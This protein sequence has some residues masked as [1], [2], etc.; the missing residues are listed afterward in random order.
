MRATW[1]RRMMNGPIP[2]V[3]ARYELGRHAGRPPARQ[4][5]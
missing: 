2:V 1:E 5:R 3:F 4:R